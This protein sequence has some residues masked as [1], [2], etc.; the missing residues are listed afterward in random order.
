MPIATAAPVP[1]APS[2]PSAPSAEER[3]AAIARAQM[4]QARPPMPP[5]PPVREDPAP[6]A[7]P[8]PVA[9][10]PAPTPAPITP[11]FVLV[12][13][14]VRVREGFRERDAVCEVETAGIRISGAP[15]TFIAWPEAR[16]IKAERGLVTVTTPDRAVRMA[17]AI[18]G[19]GEP[20]LA[21]LFARVLEDGGAGTLKPA[22][23]ALHELTLGLD[24]VLEG[25]VDADDPVVPLA[26]GVFT[27]VAGV[28]L[29]AAI[30]T[31]VMLAARVTSPSEGFVLLPR[32]AAIDPRV[33]V[34]AFAT[35]AALSVAVGRYALGAAAARWARGTL[36]GWHRN[37]Q[38]A[39]DFARKLLARV[40][41]WPRI[42]A[43]VAA[44]AVVTLFPSA[45]ARTVIDVGG[46]HQ[47]SGLPLFSHERGWPEL[48][49]VT[50][51]AVSPSER[52]EGF[53]TQLVFADG[54]KVSTRGQDVTGGSQ[55]QLYDFV[56][57]H[58]R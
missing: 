28:V 54:A 31:L 36:R 26:V 50:P 13:Q 41:L 2:A 10:Q 25:F 17:V 20:D 51:I 55:R 30:P 12:R 46:V 16:S 37:S 22:E 15:E 9:A 6:L 5:T 38:G 29:L 4:I 18:D 11:A 23:G 7:R 43:L 35:S 53:E 34:A 58:G 1:A 47:A 44:V 21:P 48:T 24:Q 39:E 14:N 8:V 52:A 27:V 33:I 42:A 45:F 57:V 3:L 49:E 56:L 19:V 32:L 40:A